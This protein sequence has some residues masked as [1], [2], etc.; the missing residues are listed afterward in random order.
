MRVNPAEDAVATKSMLKKVYLAA[1]LA[2]L[3][4]NSAKANV[5]DSVFVKK[6]L[7]KTEVD[8]LYSQ[9][10]QDGVHSAV[11]GGQGTEKL[12]VFAPSVSVVSS[13]NSVSWKLKTGTD[14]ITSASTDNI[15]FVQSSASRK[16]A[17]TYANLSIAKTYPNKV[18]AE[19]GTGFSVE[20]DY[21]SLPLAFTLK[22]TSKNKMRDWLIESKCYF[23]DLRWGRLNPN[24]RKP[25]RLIYP[26]EL[27][28][29]N[30]FD[31]EKRQSYNLKIGLTQ[32]VNKR[33]VIGIFPLFTIQNGLLAT[34]FHRVV[35][36]NL[37][38]RVEN[39]P[40][41]RLKLALALKW[42]S[43][44]G[45]NIVLKNTLEAYSDNFG[46]LALG[47]ENETSVKLKNGIVLSPFARFYAQTA[48]N[49]F[50]PYAVHSPDQLYYCSDYDFSRF[51]SLKSG[52]E[53][54][55]NNHF[56]L[57]KNWLLKQCQI[58]YAYY[59]RNDGLFA[60]IIS[61]GINLQHHKQ[62]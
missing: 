28:A 54:K 39:L 43:F 46:I 23:D 55:L 24:Y 7:R 50:A 62:S 41:Q 15:D 32:I 37:E 31:T 40:N 10:I 8:I 27:R 19:L 45:G 44:R 16:D 34:P 25:V 20:S 21:L 17:R 56:A 4:F 26:S 60:H 11:T 35:F 14:L 22:G 5:K 48:S 49:Y 38:T 1:T 3:L 61:L 57:R 51:Y 33:N 59:Y 52:L 47:F 29:T 12:M 58:R 53:V 42:N 6:K 18:N 36:N 2:L 13:G 9:Y 30:W